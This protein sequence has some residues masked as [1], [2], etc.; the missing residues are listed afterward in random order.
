MSGLI[1]AGSSVTITSRLLPP[2]VV[3]LSGPQPLPTEAGAIGAGL[4]LKLLAPTFTVTLAGQQLTQ[5]SPAGPAARN[6]WPQVKWG[7]VVAGFGLAFWI[8]RK[9]L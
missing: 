9:I 3:N 5:F 8:V 6:Y 4:A 7:L 2:I 1:P